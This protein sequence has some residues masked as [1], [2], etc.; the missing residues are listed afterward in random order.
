ME[1]FTAENEEKKMAIARIRKEMC[2]NCLPLPVQMGQ[3]GAEHAALILIEP[4]CTHVCVHKDLCS[5]DDSPT[6]SP[7]MLL[8][9]SEFRVSSVK[10]PC[11][12]CR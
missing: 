2:D 9:P 10:S 11:F 3:P 12:S 1:L 8:T 5:P 4:H 7:E 6:H